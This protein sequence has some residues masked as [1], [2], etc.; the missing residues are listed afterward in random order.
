MAAIDS[1]PLELTIASSDTAHG[2]PAEVPLSFYPCISVDYFPISVMLYYVD[3]MIV[4]HYPITDQ[5]FTN[6]N[7]RLPY[8]TLSQAFRGRVKV[9]SEANNLTI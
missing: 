8:Y 1:N 9:S 3:I 2:S 4:L 5:P 6:Y 7:T